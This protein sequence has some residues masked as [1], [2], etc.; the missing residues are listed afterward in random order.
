MPFDVGIGLIIGTLL[1]S[2]IDYPVWLS[3]LIGVG[4]VLLPDLD[5]LYAWAKT[6]KSPSS[7]HRDGLHYP[8]IVVPL[9]GVLGWLLDPAI[10]ITLALGTLAHFMHDSVGIGFGVK[11]LYPLVNKSY[12][13][14]FQIKTP[15][16]KDIPNRLFYAWDDT[17][18]AEMIRKY[19]YDDWIRFV[20][21]QPNP[22]G[23][24]EY[25]VL[26]TGIV[27]AATFA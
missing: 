26:L 11:W 6:K 24:F 23:I 21:F 9:T 13:F 12:L 22:W 15:T 3:L 7:T 18:R 10:G 25:T 14:L 20:Y 4:A 8:L 2:H 19:R 27:Y 17:E 5:Y 1:G 16:N